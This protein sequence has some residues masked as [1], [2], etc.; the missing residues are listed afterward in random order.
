M[1]EKL[2]NKIYVLKTIK[3][4]NFQLINLNSYKHYAK[5]N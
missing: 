3:A 4:D 1:N 5:I 2:D